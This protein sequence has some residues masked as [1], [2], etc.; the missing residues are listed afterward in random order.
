[1]SRV[2]VLFILFSIYFV[3]ESKYKYNYLERRKKSNKLGVKIEFPSSRYIKER[4]RQDA[5]VIDPIFRY[6][7]TSREVQFQLDAN[8][9]NL[10]YFLRCQGST[11][12][13]QLLI[14]ESAQQV[15]RTNHLR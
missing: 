10:P 13:L 3:S 5:K 7:I 9:D 6:Y 4:T 1:M 11:K 15:I 12:S 14:P 2:I 8:K